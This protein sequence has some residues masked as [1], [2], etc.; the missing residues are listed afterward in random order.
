MKLNDR[1]NSPDLFKHK[2]KLYSKRRGKI[3]HL[4]IHHSLTDGGDYEAFSRYHVESNNWP[5]IGYTYVINK[6]GSVDQCLDLNVKSYHVG[7]HNDYSLG[8]CMVGDFRDSKPTE[9]QYQSLIELC[10]MLM[11]KLNI[12]ASNVLGHSE[13]KGFE[14]KK[15]PEIDMEA[16]RKALEN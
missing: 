10:K 9:P 8:I 7:N 11:E 16:L 12:P 6:D 13:Y 1:R 14:W 3:T 2:V 5:S 4:A 15:C